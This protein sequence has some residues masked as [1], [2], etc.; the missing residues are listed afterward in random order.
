MYRAFDLMEAGPDR[1]A[2]MFAQV[3]EGFESGRLKPLPVRSFPVREA[4][5]ALRFMSQA[6][7]VGKLALRPLREPL[8]PDGSVLVTGGLGAIGLEVARRFAERGVRHLVLMGRRGLATPGA[9]AAV[10]KLEALG[11]RVTVEPGDVADRDA[12]SRVVSQIPPELP[13]RGVIH[14]AGVLDDGVLTEQSAERFERVMRPKAEG[15]WNLHVLTET[16]DLDIFVL[17]SSIAGTLGSSGQSGYT[18]ANAYL[19]GLAAYRRAQG[20][21]GVSLAWG[22]WSEGGLA[23]ALEPDAR[24]RLARQGFG[25]IPRDLGI[26]LFEQAITRP[27]AQ[28][29][30]APLDLRAVAKAFG[31]GVPALWRSMIR[32]PPARREREGGWARSVAEMFVRRW[33][34]CWGWAAARVG[35]RKTRRSTSSAWIR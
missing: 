8:R 35:W 19:D 31:P 14:A 3:V 25:A 30:L 32:V 13:L 23:A 9:A 16:L 11:A 29:V 12:L 22:A 27:E 17:F 28:L 6:R 15:A 2:S 7:H 5:A 21:P 1:I 20:L 34:W 18:A 4:E 33:H 24:A 10:S 26:Q